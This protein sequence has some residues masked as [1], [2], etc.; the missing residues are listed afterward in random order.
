M[1]SPLLAAL[2]LALVG[3]ALHLTNPDQEAFSSFL[4]EHVQHSLADD[5]P[6]ET[7]MGKKL[8]KGLGQLAGVA[9]HAMAER[10]DLIVA[11]VY[12]MQIAGDSH[13]FVGIAGQFFTVKGG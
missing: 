11:S 8:R 6:G 2:L 1:K 13:V 9:A 12:T 10:Q 4:A 7:E 5:E 3:G